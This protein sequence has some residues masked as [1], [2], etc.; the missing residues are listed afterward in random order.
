MRLTLE[1]AF[2]LAAAIF[3]GAITFSAMDRNAH[4]PAFVIIEADQQESISLMAH[5]AVE[6]DSIVQQGGIIL[7]QAAPA[8]SLEGT[9]ASRVVI[10]E[11]PNLETARR[12]Y[13]SSAK[14]AADENRA[15][16]GRRVVVVQGATDWP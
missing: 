10:V 9:P 2:A 11:W 4:V 12:W 16:G 13:R 7:T 6:S 1:V 15:T 3:L 5:R 14:R 8:E